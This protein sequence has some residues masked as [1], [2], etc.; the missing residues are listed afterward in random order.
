M[1]KKCFCCEQTKLISDF[2]RHPGMADGHL[3][4]CKECCKTAAIKN[5]NENIERVRAYDRLRG[6]LLHRRQ[7]VA[8]Y[9]RT[10]KGKESHKI[11]TNK[12]K[13]SHPNRRAAHH[14]LTNALRDGRIERKPCE[15]CGKEAHAHHPDYD[16]PLEVVWL[17]PLHHK[18]AHDVINQGGQP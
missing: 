1:E 15:I 9:Q 11:A 2:Y 16:R 6:K 18:E 14:I 7:A 17:C 13:E 4:K 3:G 8:E 5:R 10:P 12:W